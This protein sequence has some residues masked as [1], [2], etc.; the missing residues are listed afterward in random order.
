MK[1]KLGW[2]LFV[3][4]ILLTIILGAMSRVILGSVIWGFIFGM[5]I[6]GIGWSLAHPKSEKQLA[7]PRSKTLDRILLWFVGI[8]LFLIIV[9]AISSIVGTP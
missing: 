7:K 5:V 3:L 4:G 1:R 6:V 9:F 8:I 2:I